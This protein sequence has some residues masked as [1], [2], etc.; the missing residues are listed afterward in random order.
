LGFFSTVHAR[1]R[2]PPRYSCIEDTQRERD[3]LPVPSPEIRLIYPMSVG[4][5]G[6]IGKRCDELGR[7]NCKGRA[8]RSAQSA[9]QAGN[10]WTAFDL[11]NARAK[12]A[13]M[14]ADNLCCIAL[15][16]DGPSWC[17]RPETL[18]RRCKLRRA[19]QCPAIETGRVAFFIP[20]GVK[21]VRHR[22][23][24]EAQPVSRQRRQPRSRRANPGTL[25][26][27]PLQECSGGSIQGGDTKMSWTFSYA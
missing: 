7:K 8:V 15:H 13:R 19:L 18:E 22:N 12:S 23:Y 11:L 25:A 3:E 1:L 21:A 20:Q 24:I 27:Q 4:I 10:N 9:A 16:F 6:I 14:T 5:V 17:G 2:F 26:L